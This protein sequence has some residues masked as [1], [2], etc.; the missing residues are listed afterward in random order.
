MDGDF[1][2]AAFGDLDAD[3]TGIRRTMTPELPDDPE[4][5]QVAPALAA[6]IDPA[7]SGAGPYLAAVTARYAATLRTRTPK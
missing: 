2:D 6:G 3:L 1:L 4:P 7:S 5:E